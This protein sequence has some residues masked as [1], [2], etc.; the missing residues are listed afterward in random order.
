ML[1]EFFYMNS[2]DSLAQNLKCTYRQFPEHF[3]WY[4]G[5][6]KWEPR[7]QKD[8]I[9]RIVTASPMEGERYFLRL[10]LTHVKSPTSFDDLR[11]INGA[12]VRTFREAA[13]LRVYF[14]SDKS[15]QQCLEEAIMYHMPYSL[16]RLF[17]TLLVHFP[18]SNARYIWEQFEEP[19]FEDI[20]RTPQISVDQ[21]RF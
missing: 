11:T 15:Q 8:C 17:A 3:V 21:I 10:L 12:Y 9:G 16:R 1:T 4:P 2:T 18:P 19:L 13:I 14:E 5:R 6:R 20:S 7:K